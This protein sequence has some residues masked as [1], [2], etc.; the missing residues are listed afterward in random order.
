M[1]LYLTLSFPR[2]LYALY[3]PFRTSAFFFFFDSAKEGVTLLTFEPSKTQSPV[4]QAPALTL[5]FTTHCTT[6]EA[7]SLKILFRFFVG[8]FFAQFAHCEAI[9]SCIYSILISSWSQMC[10]ICRLSHQ[11]LSSAKCLLTHTLALRKTP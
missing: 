8:G 6:T 11:S 5:K 9:R 4:S 1:Y 2:Y 3:L 7:N 10:Q